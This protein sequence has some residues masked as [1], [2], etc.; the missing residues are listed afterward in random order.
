MILKKTKTLHGAH[1]RDTSDETKTYL[2]EQ[3]DA[4]ITRFRNSDTYFESHS[5]HES[6]SI[7]FADIWPRW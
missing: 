1:K 6:H 5:P 4:L 2:I 7:N 3:E